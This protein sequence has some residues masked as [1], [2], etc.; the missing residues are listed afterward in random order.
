MK[1]SIHWQIMDIL[2]DLWKEEG[3]ILSEDLE[4]MPLTYI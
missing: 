2:E 1:Y 3:K 4:S